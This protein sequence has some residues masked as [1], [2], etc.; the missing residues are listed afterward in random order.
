MDVTFSTNISTLEINPMQSQIL[1]AGTGD[2]GIYKSTDA[3]NSWIAVNTGLTFLD[4][5]VLAFNPLDPQ[6][7]YAG[8]HDAGVFK[9]TDAGSSWFAVNG[10]RLRPFMPVSQQECIKARMGGARGLRFPQGCLCV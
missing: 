4:V 9:S 3:G 1:Y 8:T 10:W 2:G 5:D 7:L 6:T